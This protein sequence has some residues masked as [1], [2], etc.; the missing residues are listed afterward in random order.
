MMSQWWVRRSSSAVVILASLKTL[1]CASVSIAARSRL[2]AL[3]LDSDHLICLM[4]A[5]IER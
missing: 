2:A 3:A 1:G 5:C 4:F